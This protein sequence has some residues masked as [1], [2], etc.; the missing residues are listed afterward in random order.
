M[1]GS[2]I[3][4]GSLRAIAAAVLLLCALA[5]PARAEDPV[6]VPWT[7]LLPS[8]AAPYDPDDPDICRAGRVS[9]VD[10]VIREMTRRFDPL[11]ASC[12]HDAVFALAYLR[13]TE[14]YRLAVE[15]PAFFADNGF[16]NHEDAYF[17]SLY[18]DAYDAWHAGRGAG[19]P[20]AW[21]IAFEQAHARTVK[22]SGDLLLGMSAHINRDL[23]FALERVGLFTPDGTSRKPD[24][25]KV[26]EILSRIEGPIVTEIAERFDPSVDDLNAPGTLDETALFQLVAGWRESAWRNA[27]RL[28]AATTPE[29]HAA[30][31]QQVEDGA[32]AQAM[33]IVR[34][35]AY[36]PLVESTAARDAWCAVHHG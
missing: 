1:S 28:V 33:A 21:A 29:Q 27:E 15:D 30:V 31:A 16:V 10:N 34:S 35:T 26:D 20:R 12:D 9:C 36:A 2:H 23:P 11:A 6:F 17:A 8:I 19:T 18:F 7:A 24:H 25:D 5:H 3:R 32:A 13:T 14:A 22:G 4:S